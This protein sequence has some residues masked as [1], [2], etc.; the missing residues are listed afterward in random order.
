M[1][2]PEEKRYNIYLLKFTAKQIS[3][4]LNGTVIGNPEVEVHKLSK[5][6]EGDQGSLTF[7]SNPKYNSWLY[8]THASVVIVKEDFV[9]DREV[10]STLIKVDDPYLAFTKV[11]EYYNQ[12]KLHKSGLESPHFMDKSVVYGSDLYLGAF[13]YLSANVRIG[14]NVKIYPN[15]FI[16]EN[17]IIGNNTTIFAGSKIYSESEIG[18]DCTIHSGTV[19]GCDGFGFAPNKNGDYSKIPQTGNVIIENNVDIGAGTTID[20]ATLG[21]TIIR[22]G[23]KL[24][25]QIHIAHNVEIGKHTVIAAQTGVAGSTKIG[26][27]CK[28]GGQ[29][30]IVGHITIGDNVQIQAQSGIGKSIPDN[31][32]VQGSPAIPY[33]DFNKSYVHFK[34]L[35]KI[36]SRLDD[37]DKKLETKK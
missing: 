20:R 30:G 27:N 24:D 21:S 12:I 32:T 2:T 34:N 31:E 6:E 1:Q 10:E 22:T 35:P 33:H 29:V 17:V 14:N 26:N 16:G 23:V 15:V 13:S 28:I 4:I 9:P 3:D 25:N 36:T 18:D 7:L 5:I 19:I 11:L 8:T 37:L